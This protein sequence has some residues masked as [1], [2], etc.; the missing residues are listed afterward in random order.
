MA[1]S[2]FLVFI[3]AALLL[4]GCSFNIDFGGST[5]TPEATLSTNVINSSGYTLSTT[6]FVSTSQ[7]FAVYPP[8][9]WE[10]QE[11]NS[12][13]QVQYISTDGATIIS[14]RF[15]NTG[16]TLD[17]SAFENYINAT[18]ENYYAYEDNYSE[19][20]REMHLDQ[21]YGMVYVTYNYNNVRI[22]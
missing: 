3:A 22:I 17:Q 2:G 5:A 18:Q 12:E 13:I 16:Y 7:A 4:S 21:G 1:K 10:N 8:E 20:S 15:T 14:T 9:G 19:I 6:Q 11:K